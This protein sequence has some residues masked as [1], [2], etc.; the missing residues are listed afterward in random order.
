MRIAMR[1]PMRTAIRTIVGTLTIV[2]LWGAFPL[3]QQATVRIAFDGGRVTLTAT[4]AL[5]TDVLSEW[6]R[7]GGTVISGADRLAPARISVNL[8]AVEEWSAIVQMIGSANGILATGRTDGPAGSSRLSTVMFAPPAGASRG[9]LTRPAPGDPAAP[10]QAPGVD[11]NLPE[12]RFSYPA[13]AVG[14][15]GDD[16]RSIA[17]KASALQTTSAAS[18]APGTP[19]LMPEMRFQ[20]VAPVATLAPETDPKPEDKK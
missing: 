15:S 5:I 19:L 17:A 6:A 16:P 20:Y 1:T 14:V 18:A 9:P 7:V 12:A 3:G 2:M 11:L 4:D 8:V 13:P 10:T